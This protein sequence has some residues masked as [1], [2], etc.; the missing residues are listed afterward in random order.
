MFYLGDE[1]GSLV[2]YHMA[3]Y[4]A[5]REPYDSREPYGSI[6][7]PYGCTAPIRSGIYSQ[8]TQVVPPSLYF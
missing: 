7:L 2:F 3:P 4:T 8:I 5:P 1:F 6:R